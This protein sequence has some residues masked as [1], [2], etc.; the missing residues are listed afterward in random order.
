MSNNHSDDD[1]IVI[2]EDE[3]RYET[4]DENAAVDPADDD[5]LAANDQA[6]RA[7]P[8]EAGRYGSMTSPGEAAASD[9]SDLDE[10]D[11]DAPD[12][13]APGLDEPG[14]AADAD[15]DTHAVTEPVTLV[16]SSDGTGAEAPGY[17]GT[18]AADR[19]DSAASDTL[20]S[21]TLASDTTG[22]GTVN[23]S[24]SAIPMPG[25]TAAPAASATPAAGATPDSNWPQIQSLF[26]DDPLAAVQQAADV[27]GGA[28]AAL[29]AAANNREQTL[30]GGWQGTGTGTEDLRTALREYRDLAGRLSTLAKDL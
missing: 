7:V 23:G 14:L 15:P 18:L 25:S 22:T 11:L 12:L 29:T 28:L 8:G 9:E 27:V 21:D 24:G 3:A 10:P 4:R 1:V 16:S 13:D 26:V 20:A 19:A 5:E 30:R 17:S 2:S 6:T